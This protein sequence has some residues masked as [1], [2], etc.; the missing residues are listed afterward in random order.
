MGAP[1]LFTSVTLLNL[2]CPT[3][4]EKGLCHFL[5]K[6]GYSYLYMVF[7]VINGINQ[8]FSKIKG[9]NIHFHILSTKYQHFQTSLMLESMNGSKTKPRN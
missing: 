2:H 6:L 7:K 4:L 8:T 9:K 3:L 5:V 1:K